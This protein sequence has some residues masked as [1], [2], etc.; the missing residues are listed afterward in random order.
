[1]KVSSLRSAVVG[2]A[3]LA[4]SAGPA[5]AD[6]EPNNYL[7]QAEGPI[8]ASVSG[9]IS[10][11]NDQD[12]Y[13]LYVA[14]QAQLQ[15]KVVRLSGSCS[16]DAF[17]RNDFGASV[18][19]LTVASSKVESTATYTTP[20]GTNRFFLQI[21]PEYSGCQGQG[22]RVEFG[23]TTAVVPGAAMPVAQPF[24][25][26]P[27][28]TSAQSAGPLQADVT[29]RSTIDTSNDVDYFWFYA[30]GAF[31]LE[32]TGEDT[33]DVE[34]DLYEADGADA[35]DWLRG[36]TAE[37]NE[38]H[39][40]SVTPSGFTKYYLRLSEACVGAA[41][42]FR[43]SPAS[44]IKQ[45]PPPPPPPLVT[46]P[47]NPAPAVAPATPGSVRLKAKRRSIVVR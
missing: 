7:Y 32:T 26:E 17:L 37:L 23:P 36:T 21:A 20:A 41:A 47:T 2:A 11:S 9:S 13:V 31:S 8:G 35:G 34:V 39:T 6:V 24:N 3:L 4:L 25:P 19:S 30:D 18:R 28:E 42:R 15:F 38:V 22:Y 14:S 5:F 12:W 29:Y 45:E 27:N 40:V 10:T 43:L 44:A 33:C 16:I 1:M 46:P